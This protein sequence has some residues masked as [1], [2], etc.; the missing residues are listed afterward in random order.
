MAVLQRKS[1][2]LRG[3]NVACDVVTDMKRFAV[4]AGN[5]RLPAGLSYQRHLSTRTPC[6]ETDSRPRHE[7]TASGGSSRDA[8]RAGRPGSPA[9]VPVR[10][11]P[12]INAGRAILC[13]WSQAYS[14]TFPRRAIAA[15]SL[16]S[17]PAQLGSGTRGEAQPALMPAQRMPMATI[18]GK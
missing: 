14:Q 15:G 2:V 18:R 12:A 4:N 7:R 9:G 13:G 17:L 3:V 11:R 6:A 5:T 1:L 8:R 10:Q 16:T